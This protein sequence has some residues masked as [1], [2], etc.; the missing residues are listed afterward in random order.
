MIAYLRRRWNLLSVNFFFQRRPKQKLKKACSRF[1]LPLS[2]W[3][4]INS[5]ELQWGRSILWPK[6][7][8]IRIFK[9]LDF[10]F[11]IKFSSFRNAFLV[12]SISSKKRTKTSLIVVKLNSFLC[13][14]EE[15]SAWKNRFDFVWPL[16]TFKNITILLLPKIFNSVFLYLFCPKMC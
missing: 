3:P 8:W 16:E 4:P 13:F 14:L 1:V 12:S 11:L 10:N 15:T 6:Y 7:F 9:I 2:Q 5:K